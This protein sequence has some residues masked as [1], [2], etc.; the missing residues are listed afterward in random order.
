M[1]KMTTREETRLQEALD[2]LMDIVMEN[3]IMLH[4]ICDAINFHHARHQRENEEDFIRNIFA[5]LLSSGVDI[6]GML[7][8]KGGR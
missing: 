2:E 6:K 7:G 5:N 1:D 8:S 4:Q 3:N